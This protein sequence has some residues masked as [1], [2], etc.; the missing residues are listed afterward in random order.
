MLWNPTERLVSNVGTP[1]MGGMHRFMYLVVIKKKHQ[2]ITA[3]IICLPIQENT[4]KQLMTTPMLYAFM[5]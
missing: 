3:A 2:E 1:V 4:M 5:G